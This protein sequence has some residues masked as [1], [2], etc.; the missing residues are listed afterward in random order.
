MSNR[1][2]YLDYIAGKT[3]YA[4]ARGADWTGGTPISG[5]PGAEDNRQYAFAGLAYTESYTVYEQSGASPASTDLAIGEFLGPQG[6]VVDGGTGAGPHQLT[7]SV[8]DADAVGVPNCI[9]TLVGTAYSGI[10]DSS[11]S[12]IFNLDAATYDVR[13]T[14]PT[15]YQAPADQQ[16]VLS[17][18]A[19]LSFTLDPIPENTPPAWIG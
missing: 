18:D 5:T 1:T 10:T 2:E 8:N 17:G 6:A 13:V 4:L 7:V 15:E 19:A 9:V 12:V 14:P 16:I 11:G 3:L